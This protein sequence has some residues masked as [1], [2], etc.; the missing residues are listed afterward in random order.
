MHRIYRYVVAVDSGAAPNVDGGICT[1]TV[2]K[3]QIRRGTNPGDWI[4]GLW[5]APH[6]TRITYAMRVGSKLGFEDYWNSP[7]FAA[8]RPDRSKTPDNIYRRDGFGELVQVSNPTH[9]PDQAGTDLRGQYALVADIFWYFGSTECELPETFRSLDLSGSRRGHRVAHWNDTQLHA[10]VLWLDTK[11]SGVLGSPRDGAG[12]EAE[13][14]PAP[15]LG[16][17]R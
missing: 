4:I 2:C 8:K 15:G 5:P 13:G 16:C 9:G 14:A 3:P 1:C 6:R 7:E 12:V 17:N 10:F 11:G